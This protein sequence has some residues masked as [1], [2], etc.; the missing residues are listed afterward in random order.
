MKTTV[1][2]IIP[3]LAFAAIGGAIAFAPIAN[4]DSSPLLPYGTNPQPSVPIG[5]HWSDQDELNT[6]N[7]DVDLPF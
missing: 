6:T 2:Q 3:W 5:Q 4:A 7:G 1:K